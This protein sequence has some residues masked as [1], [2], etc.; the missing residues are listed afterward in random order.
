[1]IVY[2][3][4]NGNTLISDTDQTQIGYTTCSPVPM[5]LCFPVSP[6]NDNDDGFDDDV[7]CVDRFDITGCKI[8]LG[9]H[10]IGGG[11]DGCPMSDQLTTSILE[12]KV[13]PFQICM[14]YIQDDESTIHN[15]VLEGWHSLQENLVMSIPTASS[16]PKWDERV[17]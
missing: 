8:L 9:C 15:T 6:C 5:A 4:R 11:G 3:T 14:P 13:D 7:C 12:F 17:T 2:S 10:M 1:M 16:N